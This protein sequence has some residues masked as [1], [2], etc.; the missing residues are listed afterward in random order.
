MQNVA[1]KG[2]N[3]AKKELSPWKCVRSHLV[4]SNATA[5]ERSDHVRTQIYVSD[6]VSPHFPCCPSRTSLQPCAAGNYVRSTAHRTFERTR[7]R[8][9]RLHTNARSAVMH[10]RSYA[11]QNIERMR[12]CVRTQHSAFERTPDLAARFILSINRT[13]GFICFPRLGDSWDAFEVPFVAQNLPIL[14]CKH[15]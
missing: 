9:Q 12:K 10:L 13:C 15:S 5:V 14:H 3:E 7:G 6:H 2:R 1:K 4:R 11:H 8:T